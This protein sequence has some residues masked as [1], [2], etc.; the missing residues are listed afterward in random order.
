M[1]KGEKNDTIDYFVHIAA[2]TDLRNT[3]G[4]KEVLIQCN[5]EGPVLVNH[6]PEDMIKYEKL[7]YKTVGLMYTPYINNPPIIFDC[8]SMLEICKHAHLDVANIDMRNFK[9][10]MDFSINT[11]F[12][13]KIKAAFKNIHSLQKLC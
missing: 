12:G 4:V 5:I 1:S 3:D 8:T 9:L 10:L 2:V 6:I 11:H 7:Y 13:L